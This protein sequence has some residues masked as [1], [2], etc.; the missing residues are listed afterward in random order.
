[1]LKYSAMDINADFNTRVVLHSPQI[2]WQNSPMLGVQR[3]ILDHIGNEA[4][5]RATSIVRFDTCSHFSPHVHAG[6][7][8][9]IVLD[10]VFQDEHGDYPAGSYIRNPPQTSHSPRSNIGC[11]IFV[12]L[13][14]FDL[15]DRTQVN[16]DMHSLTL[17]ADKSRPGVKINTLFTN[18]HEKVNLEHWHANTNVTVDTK[19]GAEILVLEGN[20][21]EG[22]DALNALSWMRIPIGVAFNA[23]T[24][25]SGTKVWIKTG[26]LRFTEN[27]IKQVS[28]F[29]A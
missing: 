10:G 15:S 14:Q 5:A 18:Q 21:N 22:N 1:M 27:E 9:F 25:P 7:E 11:T 4:A 2:E 28:S 8:E 26:H 24:G 29:R 17:L 16:I 19:N 6:G 20:F 12:K 23:H 3:R 13:W